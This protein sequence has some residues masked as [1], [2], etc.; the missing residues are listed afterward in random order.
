MQ[1]TWRNNQRIHVQVRTSAIK[2]SLSRLGPPV[3]QDIL[4]NMPLYGTAEYWRTTMPTTMTKHTIV[5]W[6]QAKV[7][8]GGVR[9]NNVP[10]KESARG[11]YCWVWES[12]AIRT[13]VYWLENH[14]RN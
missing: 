8:A 6:S 12:H 3:S 2:R 14:T 4:C 9:W 11:A 5:S 13:H 10:K 7:L 1:Q